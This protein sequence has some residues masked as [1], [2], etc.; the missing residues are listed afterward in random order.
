MT[1]AGGSAK[2][3]YFCQISGE[4]RGPMGASEL[5]QLAQRGVLRPDDL[6]WQENANQKIPARLVNGL[7]GPVQNRPA[8]ATVA[9]PRAPAAV[10]APPPPLPTAL[11]PPPMVQQMPMQEAAVEQSQPVESAPAAQAD[12]GPFFKVGKQFSYKGGGT[13]MGAI[14]VSP[15]AIYLVKARRQ[16]NA[17]G[18]G[19]VGVLIAAATAGTADDTRT[20][21]V[22]QL[23]EAVRNAVDPKQKNMMAD[24]I[25]LPRGAVTHLKIGGINNVMKVECGGNQFK[26][27]TSYFKSKLR[28]FLT[29]SGWR[30]NQEIT[31]TTAPMH[32][33]GLGRSA[34]NPPPKQRHIALRILFVILAILL[35]IGVIALRVWTDSNH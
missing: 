23:P 9:P 18:H 22:G 5:R 19:L 34:E 1:D 32:G 14:H 15:T 13:W 3:K 7:F 2:T 20:C 33:R 35:I 11:A 26:L 16:Q 29:D 31:P 12:A 17:Y 4:K 28:A 10:P 8:A 6:V 27:N 24:V 30:M 21:F 25:V